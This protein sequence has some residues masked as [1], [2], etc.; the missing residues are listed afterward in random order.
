MTR[1]AVSASI[2]LGLAAALAAAALFGGGAAAD[3]KGPIV[4]M[5]RAA[6]PREKAFTFLLPRGWTVEGGIFRLDASRAGGPGNAMEAKVD[7]AFKREPAGLVM[8]PE[9]A[10]GQLRRRPHG[11]GYLGPGRQLPGHAG[12]RHADGRAVPGQPLPRAPSRGRRRPGRRAAGPLRPGP[13]H[14]Q[15]RRDAQRQPP[16]GRPPARRVLCRGQGCHLHRAGRAV[17]GS[18][19]HRSRRFPRRRG[20]LGQRLHHGHAGPGSR[21]GGVEASSSTS[22]WIL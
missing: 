12:G 17:Q 9:A 6:E 13:G 2:P 7:I 19:I 5:S 1:K 10:E 16:H 8:L 21:G 15:G 18:P 11:Q 3:P 4:F 20:P 14:R 22:S